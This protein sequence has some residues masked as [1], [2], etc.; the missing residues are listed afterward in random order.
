MKFLRFSHILRIMLL[1][2]S[3]SHLSAKTIRIDNNPNA[4]G[5]DYTSLKD[6]YS[7]AVAGDTLLLVASL[8][9]YGD[10]TSSYSFEISKKVHLLGE[11]IG[12]NP[13]GR[14]D[15]INSVRTRLGQLDIVAGAEGS[16]VQAIDFDGA[17]E[18][19]PLL[20]SQLRIFTKNVVVARCG[21]DA[22][23]LKGNT[24][25]NTY[26][27]NCVITQNFFRKEHTIND[28]GG[29][30]IEDQCNYNIITNNILPFIVGTRENAN[31]IIRNNTLY[32]PSFREVRV[33][34]AFASDIKN[35]IILAVP[36]SGNTSPFFTNIKI[37]NNAMLNNVFP[38]TVAGKDIPF[39]NNYEKDLN[40]FGATMTDVIDATDLTILNFQAL[41]KLKT[42]SVAIGAGFRGGDCGA[43]GGATPYVISGTG[44]LP[45]I[46]EFTSVSGIKYQIKAQIK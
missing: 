26:A 15:I 12:A 6:G 43:F 35:N 44:V 34:S 25:T 46:T 1:T 7:A 29:V 11:G 40:V 32:A 18:I 37:E 24:T 45:A 30:F 39:K 38:F 19:D 14:A 31:N 8:T 20:Q 22:V 2:L 21:L 36:T 42:G 9:P 3:V 5:A 10:A 41:Y 28:V 33:I 4:T 27:T 16:S 17:K 13:E 23:L